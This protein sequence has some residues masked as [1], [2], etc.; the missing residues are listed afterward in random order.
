MDARAE[1]GK[2][3]VWVG[4]RSSVAGPARALVL[5]HDVVLEA[6]SPD[7]AVDIEPPQ[8]YRRLVGLSHAARAACLSW[9]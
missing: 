8:V 6:S 5:P 3:F 1:S 9:A 2:P 7:G 4:L